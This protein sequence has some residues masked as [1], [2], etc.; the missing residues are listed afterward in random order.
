[1]KYVSL[2]LEFLTMIT[3]QSRSLLY[4]IQQQKKN[5]AESVFQMMKFTI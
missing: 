5:V 2:V 1:M 4:R 3:I